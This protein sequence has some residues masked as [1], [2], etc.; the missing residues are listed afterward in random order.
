[1]QPI[2]RDLLMADIKHSIPDVDIDVFTS[3]ERERYGIR[4]IIYDSDNQRITPHPCGVYFPDCGIPIDKETDM[5]SLD[6]K[7]AEDIGF[8]KVDLLSNTVY[9]GFVNKQEV[10]DALHADVDWSRF[11]EY[12]FVKSLPQL[13]EHVELVMDIKPESIDD[14][15]DI[16]A[17]IRPAKRQFIDDYKVNKDEVRKKLYIKTGKG[18]MF[19]KSHAYAYAAMLICFI[20]KKGSQHLI[21]M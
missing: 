21:V 11:R 7:Q 17:L 3:I 12:D 1:M 18:I 15:A 20:N 13:S 14:L 9:D 19:K 8:M 2:R 5:A 10:L 16:L 6:Y 4:A